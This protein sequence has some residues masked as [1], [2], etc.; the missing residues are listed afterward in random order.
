MKS[1]QINFFLTMN[2]QADLLAKL[3]PLGEVVYLE[4][5]SEH[6]V[7]QVLKSAEIK[8]VG[9]ERLK[10]FM[11]RSR[12]VDRIV[13]DQSQT[14]AFADIARSPLVEFS[15]CYQD[16]QLIRRGRFYFVKDFTDQ[17]GAIVRKDE[18]FVRWG[19][20]LV[21]SARRLLKRDSTSLAYFGSE[22]LQLVND[23]LRPV[24]S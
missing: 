8:Y 13:L 9:A 12:Y 18:E 10:I 6:G 2:D 21:S 15:R 11:T 24:I 3:D 14:A 19:N 20:M 5:I 4:S 23:G 16:Q 1:S 17:H 7:L 22:A